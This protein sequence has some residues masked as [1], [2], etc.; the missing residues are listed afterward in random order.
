MAFRYTKHY[1]RDE[2][3]ELLPEVRR[4]LKD[5]VERRAEAQKCEERMGGLMAPAADV[6]GPLVNAWVKALAEMKRLLDEFY[7]RQIE[8]KDID[9]GLVDFPSILDGREVFLCWE[10]DEEDI[11]V[12]HELD[13]GYAG[14]ERI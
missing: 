5:L 11:E 7:T 2:A 1:T 3:R 12:W 8:I 14:R 13:A 6:G 10:Q 4:W 9:R